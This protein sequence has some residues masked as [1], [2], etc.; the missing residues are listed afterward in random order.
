MNSV[1]AG[2]LSEDCVSTTDSP[3]TTD[4]RGAG[5][6]RRGLQLEVGYWSAK[7]GNIHGPSRMVA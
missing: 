7:I 4:T 3:P 2:L 5:G 1:A 6:Y